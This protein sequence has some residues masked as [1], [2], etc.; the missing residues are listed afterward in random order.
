[1]DAGRHQIYGAV[2]KNTSDLPQLKLAEQVS[3]PEHWLKTLPYGPYL[4]VGDGVWRHKGVINKNNLEAQVV[5][6]NNRI[7]EDMCALAELHANKGNIISPHKL[8][9][10][11]LRPPDAKIN[12]KVNLN[13]K[14]QLLNP[15]TIA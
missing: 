1:M 15:P 10:N 7:L 11:Y 5:A 2:Y 3:T 13:E 14:R 12:K 9:G 4:F 8:N 6:T